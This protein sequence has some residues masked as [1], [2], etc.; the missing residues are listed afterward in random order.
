[1]SRARARGVVA[2][3]AC[4]VASAPGL[5]RAEA[6]RKFALAVFH[7]NIQY[8]VGGLI[9]FLPTAEP[10]AAWELDEPAV[11]DQIVRES[12]EPV[13]DLFLAHP[14]WGTDIELQGLFLEILEARH[15][16]VLEH[17]AQFPGDL[18][19]A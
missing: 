13:L 14:S 17:P 1:M 15:P 5:A 8:V 9:G 7:F 3:L 11:E 6:P 2:L 19:L 4:L 10:V 12:F 16:D 18:L